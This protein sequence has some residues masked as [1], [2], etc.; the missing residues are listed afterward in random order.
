MHAEAENFFAQAAEAGYEEAE[1][2][3][4]TEVEKGHGR[5]EERRVVVTN[6]L[7]W[8]DE[9]TKNKWRDLSSLIEITSRREVKGKI[10]EEKRCYISNMILTP[11]K[12]G[13]AIRSH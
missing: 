4:A 12:A 13:K 7:D 2:T 5:I 11:K 9:K 1:C 3:V 10:S 6:Q 8:L